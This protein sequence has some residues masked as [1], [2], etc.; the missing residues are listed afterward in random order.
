M[1]NLAAFHDYD[2]RGIYGVEIDEAFFYSLGR[3]VAAYIGKGPI[4]VGHDMRLS[5]PSLSASLASGITDGGIDVVAL[6]L[7]STEMTYFASGRYDFEANIIVSASHNPPNY[8]GAK[9][10]KRGVV[11][12]HGGC[13]LDQLKQLVET[14]SFAA[15]I[16][17]GTVSYKTI[18]NDWIEHAL[19]F[20][21]VSKL[22]PLKV[23]VDAGNGM[24]GPSWSEVMKR[25]TMLDFIPL[26][27]DPDGTFPHHPA[28][29]LKD[30]NVVDLRQTVLAKQAD[31]GLALDGDA[32][33]IFFMDELGN[34]LSGTVA[35]ALLADYLLKNGNETILYNAICG[36]IVKEV[37][38]K[39]GG[40]PIRTRVGHSLIKEKM[41]ETGAVFGGEHSGHFYFGANFGAES[42]LI[43][44][45][46]V[47]QL[48]SQSDK[49][50]SHF[51]RQ[52]NKYPQSGELNFV[53]DNIDA[54]LDAVERKFGQSAISVDHLDG[55]S[56]WFDKYWFIL[57][58]SKTEPLLRLNVEADNKKD[59]DLFLWEIVSYLKTQGAVLKQ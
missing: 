29:P 45:L 18:F 53:A 54:V 12:L 35:T 27:V 57:R 34:K 30:E 21:D 26:Y 52:Y 24:G 28:D 13:G 3:A 49:K 7:I 51:A 58:A 23:V 25:L 20:I 50:L 56:V 2:I 1:K 40:R 43:A 16:Q 44:G 37:V 36:R 47:I 32:D 9:I 6:G 17:K 19:S 48:L 15:P 31:L 55:L 8:N 39:R 10:V 46:L 5:S 33:R 14:D 42:S 59:L 11:P 41:R 38:E 22:K 4:A